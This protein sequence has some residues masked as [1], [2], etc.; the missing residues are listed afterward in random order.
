MIQ[1]LLLLLQSI[2]F[3]KERKVSP[4]LPC[5]C[6][7]FSSFHS[8]LRP[9]GGQGC[10]AGASLKE[11]EL[12]SRADRDFSTL[13]SITHECTAV[14]L[15]ALFRAPQLGWPPHAGLTRTR[16]HFALTEYKKKSHSYMPAQ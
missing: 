2:F 5:Q 14:L 4:G 8:E 1:V 10:L 12:F 7:G 3:S 16:R 6:V 9:H 13:V 15:R 11:M